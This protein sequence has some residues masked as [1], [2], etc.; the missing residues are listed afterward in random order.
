MQAAVRYLEIWCPMMVLVWTCM[1]ALG[2]AEI[3]GVRQRRRKKNAKPQA[4]GEGS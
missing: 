4:A 3:A 2:V 1:I